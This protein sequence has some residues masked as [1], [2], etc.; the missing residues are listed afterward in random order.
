MF[1]GDFGWEEIG[2]GVADEGDFDAMLPIERLL[3]GEDDNHL[4]D[5][6]LHELDAVLLP[7]PEL[8]ADKEDDGDAEPMELFGEFEV[9]VREVD[10]DRD[11]GP[12]L[13]DGG[14]EAAEFSIDAG[15]VADHFCD[16]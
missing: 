14:F 13:A 11:I 15:Q 10:E 12:V 6:F 3:E 1:A 5:I 7:R 9:N 4:A 8:G 16:A 2:E